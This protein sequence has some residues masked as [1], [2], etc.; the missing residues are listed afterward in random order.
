[1]SLRPSFPH[2]LT[3][4]PGQVYLN[5]IFEGRAGFAAVPSLR[6]REGRDRVLQGGGAFRAGRVIERDAL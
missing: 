5:F 4:H 1:M 3:R 2:A 6:D